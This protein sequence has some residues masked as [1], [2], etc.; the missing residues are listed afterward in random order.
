M[1]PKRGFNKW[2]QS[3]TQS[4]NVKNLNQAELRISSGAVCL[5]CHGNWS[6]EQKHSLSERAV[7]LCALAVFWQ[8]TISGDHAALR[9]PLCTAFSDPQW[10]SRCS[11]E[12]RS[13]SETNSLQLR[14]LKGKPHIRTHKAQLYSLLTEN[15]V[16]AKELQVVLCFNVGVRQRRDLSR[17]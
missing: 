2:P 1:S 14:F 13:S 5:C 9:L 7:A 6:F 12:S 11:P 3:V 17:S 16:P 15:T 8:Q 10:Q 4:S